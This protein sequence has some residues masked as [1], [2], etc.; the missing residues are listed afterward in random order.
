MKILAAMSLAQKTCWVLSPLRGWD[1][2]LACVPGLWRW[3]ARACCPTNVRRASVRRQM[4]NLLAPLH[5]AARRRPAAAPLYAA[6]APA[7]PAEGEEE[8]EEA[9]EPERCIVRKQVEMEAPMSHAQEWKAFQEWGRANLLARIHGP[10]FRPCVSKRRFRERCARA[11]CLCAGED[12]RRAPKCT[13][14]YTG[15]YCCN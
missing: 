2:R 6:V 5:A 13:V 8:E 10:G 14:V 1:P 3:T 9:E 12:A 7:E 15:I 4:H 11:F